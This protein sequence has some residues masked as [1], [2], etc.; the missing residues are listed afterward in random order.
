MKRDGGIGERRM[1]PVRS[2]PRRTYKPTTGMRER[3]Q[4]AKKSA[5]T[6]VGCFCKRDKIERILAVG[7]K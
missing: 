4:P 6:A 1:N 7:C 3:G 2:D 5:G